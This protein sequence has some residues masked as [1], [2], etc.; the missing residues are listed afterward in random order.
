MLALSVR[1]FE[2]AAVCGLLFLLN[3][4]SSFRISINI[5]LRLSGTNYVGP[6]FAAFV[7]R[8]LRSAD[9]RCDRANHG[10]RLARHCFGHRRFPRVDRSAAGLWLS[11]LRCLVHPIMLPRA[12]MRTQRDY[13]SFISAMIIAASVARRV[14]DSSCCLPPTRLGGDAADVAQILDAPI[15]D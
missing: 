3:L 12:L 6:L 2:P 1:R 14:S 9:L 13:R 11:A 5:R 15:M 10:T 7:T 4:K 8:R